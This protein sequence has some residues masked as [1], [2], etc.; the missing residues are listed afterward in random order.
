MMK[1]DVKNVVDYFSRKG[2]TAFAL[3]R[4]YKVVDV[5]ADNE[6]E[7]I[8]IKVNIYTYKTFLQ[9]LKDF[10]RACTFFRCTR[11]IVISTKKLPGE[12]FVLAEKYDTEIIYF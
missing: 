12:L 1:K 10:D 4:D 6:K 2:Y 9:F 8:A 11:K 7:R 5:I 3:A